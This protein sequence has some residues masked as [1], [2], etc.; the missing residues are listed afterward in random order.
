MEKKYDDMVNKQN[1]NTVLGIRISDEMKDFIDE[2]ISKLNSGNNPIKYD[3]SKFIR[4]LID[5]ARRE[6]NG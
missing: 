2:C 6:Q 4:V 1:Y 5:K 3:R